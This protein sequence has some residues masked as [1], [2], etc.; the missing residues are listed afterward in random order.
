TFQ[1]IPE[2]LNVD[3]PSAA[4]EDQV[5][6]GQA[7]E[8]RKLFVAFGVCKGK[9]ATGFTRS[10]HEEK[11]QE[12]GESGIDLGAEVDGEHSPPRGIGQSKHLGV[13]VRMQHELAE[14]HLALPRQVE[15]QAPEVQDLHRLRW[16]SVHQVAPGVLDFEEIRL[17]SV[18]LESRSRDE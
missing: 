8:G 9:D 5:A 2:T 7:R 15:M 6:A 3:A 16:V 10:E 12:I 13:E 18:H 4:P 14:T 11:A 17:T 1:A